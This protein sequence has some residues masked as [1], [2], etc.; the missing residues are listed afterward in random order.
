MSPNH[1]AV[2][3]PT[4]VPHGL[5]DQCMASLIAQDQVLTDTLI[6]QNGLRVASV[7]AHWEQQGITIYRPEQNIGVSASWNYACRW[8]WIRGHDALLLLNDDLML[9]DPLTLVQFRS[10]VV[11]EPRWFYC[12]VGQGF[13]A[14]CITRAVWDEVGEFD[15]GF[16]PAYYE[17]ND[18]LWRMKLVGISGRDIDLPSKHFHSASIHADTEMDAL[19]RIAFPLNQG[20]YIAKWGGLPDRETYTVPWNGG[21]PS[22]SVQDLIEY[23][24]GI[25]R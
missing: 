2:A 20:R 4:I 23:N 15:E 5:L 12:L 3:V 9:V 10:A 19:N 21:P 8:A 16:W 11:A 24:G 17:D 14:V 13:S 25:L 22:P 18:M 6:I 1:F 7:C